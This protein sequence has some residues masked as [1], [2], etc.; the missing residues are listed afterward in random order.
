[1]SKLMFLRLS[2]TLPDAMIL[3][4]VLGDLF[5]RDDGPVVVPVGDHEDSERLRADIERKARDIPEGVRLVMRTS[6]STT[7][8]GRLVGLTPAQLMASID[9]TDERLGTGTWVLALPPHHIAGLQVLARSVLAGRTP[10]VI[11]GRVDP[12]TLSSALDDAR[13]ADPGNQSHIS[14]V[15]TQLVDALHSAEGTSALAQATSVL[16]G[17]AATPQSLVDQAKQAGIRLHLSYG[18][19][20]TCGGCVYDGLPLNGVRVAIGDPC[21]PATDGRIW[22]SGPMVMSR[23][24]DGDSGIREI[25][26]QRW[27]ATSDLGSLNDGFLSVSGRVDNVI[28]S[29]GLKISA[30]DVTDAM[31]A[32]GLAHDVVVLGIPDERW[33]SSVAAV[34]VP[35]PDAAIKELPSGGAADSATALTMIRDRIGDAI[36]REKAPQILL[37][38]AELPH[39]ESGKVDR[40][41]ARRLVTDA[42][43]QGNA[44]RYQDQAPHH[45]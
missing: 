1:M 14:L 40:Q 3:A 28:I 38:V 17:G 24:L 21:E 35:N 4:R 32:T 43:S 42:I 31:M 41:A 22:I 15:P 7:G 30:S 34:F 18:M 8:H 11:S 25:D 12:E 19:S 26:G 29:G 37:P 10:Q 20:E 2:R 16:V 44:W 23:Y 9:A 13:Q 45:S 6:G 33:G 39:L 36:G 27:F 5:T